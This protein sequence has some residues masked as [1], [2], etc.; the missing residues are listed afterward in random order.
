MRHAYIPNELL[1]ALLGLLG[2]LGLPLLSLL[3][4]WLAGGES[5]TE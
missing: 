5:H 4:L 2:L 3:S 1:L